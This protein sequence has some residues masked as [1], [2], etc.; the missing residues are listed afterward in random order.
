MASFIL[1]PSSTF[2]QVTTSA[3]IDTGLWTLN[4]KTLL[5]ASNMNYE[6]TPLEASELGLGE[7]FKGLVDV[8]CSGAC[9]ASD[10]ESSGRIVFGS[11]GSGGFVFN[12]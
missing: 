5:L 2:K 7:G 8:F 1:D 9:D 3:G 10:A 6:N 11:V 4:G 12:A